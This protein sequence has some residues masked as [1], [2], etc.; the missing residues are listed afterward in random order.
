MF[1]ISCDH[2]WYLVLRQ[3]RKTLARRDDPIDTICQEVQF[4]AGSRCVE[5]R[6]ALHLLGDTSP[7]PG[8]KLSLAGYNA[9]EIFL[10]MVLSEYI[11]LVH[12]QKFSTIIHVLHHRGDL[13]CAIA[14]DNRHR[15]RLS[16]VL[17]ENAASLWIELGL[18][19]IYCQLSRV[20]L[21]KLGF[22]RAGRRR[23]CL[24]SLSQD[25]WDCSSAPPSWH[26]CWDMGALVHL[27]PG[28][29]F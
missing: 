27:G 12:H 22:W 5:E 28:P 8:R 19:P 25:G 2:N 10:F 4:L 13:L 14:I 18:Q 11:S 20:G 26:Q 7:E 29:A 3:G 23:N 24:R 1:V 21:V 16:S 9:S 15:S 6:S 17:A